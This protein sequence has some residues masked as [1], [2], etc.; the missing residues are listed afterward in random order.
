MTN[1]FVFTDRAGGVNYEVNKDG[2]VSITNIIK[3]DAETVIKDS[4]FVEGKEI[5]VSEIKDD[6]FKS[7]KKLKKVVLGKNI[8]KIGKRAFYNCKNLKVVVIKT[9][10]LKSVGKNAFA[11]TSKKIKVYVPK[12]SLLKKYKKILSKSKIYKNAKFLYNKKML[13]NS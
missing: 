1:G 5:V 8:K 13:K 10:K 11:K 4:I 7:K 6:A 9:K 12:K 3:N 2:S